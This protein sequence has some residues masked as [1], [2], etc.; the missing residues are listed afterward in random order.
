MWLP[1]GDMIPS[2]DLELASLSWHLGF[3]HCAR[4]CRLLLHLIHEEP[5]KQAHEEDQNQEKIL[6]SVAWMVCDNIVVYK[7]LGKVDMELRVID[8]SP[9]KFHSF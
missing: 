4:D 1:T 7:G 3:D 6:E 8:R 9:E 5:S 2:G